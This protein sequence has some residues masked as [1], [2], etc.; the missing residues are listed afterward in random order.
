MEKRTVLF[1]ILVALSIAAI[2]YCFFSDLFTGVQKVVG[3]D[4]AISN[5]IEQN[6]DALEIAKELGEFVVDNTEKLI[7][8]NLDDLETNSAS[9]PTSSKE[10]D[11]TGTI[12]RVLDGDTYIVD[13]DGSETTIRLIGVDTPESVAPDEYY[14]ENTESG[15]I[16]SEIVKSYL[17][18][19]DTIFLE[20]DVGRTDPYDRTLA[21]VYFQNGTMVQRWLLSNGYAQV[22]TI[23]PNSKYAAEF[24]TLEQKAMENEVGLWAFKENL[25]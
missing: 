20:Y 6:K 3:N 7:P 19:G 9:Q 10:Y 25:E 5:L 13:I 14:K 23:Q 24:V 12:V 4:T 18:Q 2:L 22:M 8:N 21:Y 16:V 15:N 17:N 11:A 1:I